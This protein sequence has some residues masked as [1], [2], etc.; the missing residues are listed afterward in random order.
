MLY[1]NLT[2]TSSPRGLH[3]GKDPPTT[4]LTIDEDFDKVIHYGL[5]YELYNL[6]VCIWTFL[7]CFDINYTDMRRTKI[8]TEIAGRLLHDAL[9]SV[10]WKKQTNG[11]NIILTLFI[12]DTTHKSGLPVYL[13]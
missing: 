12:Q 1:L 6:E 8:P 4:F 10:P 9:A 5:P 3:I 13:I 11:L 7:I 2:G